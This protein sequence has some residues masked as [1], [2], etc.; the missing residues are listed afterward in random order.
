MSKI[1]IITDS[2]ADIPFPLVQKY[3]ISVIPLKVHLKGKSYLDGVNLSAEQFY[4]ELKQAPEFPTTS[5]PSPYDFID[6][7]Q[8]VIKAGADEI[9]SIHLSS[10]LSGTYQSAILA[11]EMIQNSRVNI[12]VFDSKSVS[13]AM[14][15]AVVAA[16]KAAQ[17]G[18]PMEEC[19]R[20]A[21]E[22]LT[23]QR[24]YFLLDTLEYLRKGGRIGKASSVVGSLLN[25]KPILSLTHLGEVVAI[26]KARGKRKATQRIFFRIQEEIPKGPISLAILHADCE[27]VADRWVQEFNSMSGYDIQETIVT[28]IGPVVGSHA[29]PN[30]IGCLVTPWKGDN[31]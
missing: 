25:I 9:L 7:Y 31:E 13:Y 23:Q 4:Q 5:Q 15:G 12:Q 6:A 26:E 22:F 10:A 2:T 27:T 14:G 28:S 20:I 3:N 21:E 19:K 24:V 18:K 16:A 29:G 17:A 8:S 1:H 11:K 30:T